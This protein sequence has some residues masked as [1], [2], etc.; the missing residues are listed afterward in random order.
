MDQMGPRGNLRDNAPERGMLRK[1]A[2]HTLGQHRAIGRKHRHGG[3]V[4]GGFD[5]ENRSCG[6]TAPL[7]ADVQ[8]GSLFFTQVRH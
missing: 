6:H 5:R 4:A 8:A 1:L 7:K 2:Q 3:L